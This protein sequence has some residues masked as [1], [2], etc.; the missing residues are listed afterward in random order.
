[1]NAHPL[2][3]VLAGAVDTSQPQLPLA[4]EGVQRY[5]WHGAFGQMLIEVHDAAAFVNGARVEPIAE[6]LRK[7]DSDVERPSNE[8]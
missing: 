8:P 5:V 6:T 7:A 1:M 4:S 2:P 3:D